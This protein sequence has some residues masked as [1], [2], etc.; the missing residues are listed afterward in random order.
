MQSTGKIEADEQRVQQAK[1][2]AL[3]KEWLADSEDKSTKGIQT[4][5]WNSAKYKT[6]FSQ[7]PL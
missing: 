4:I 5:I 6:T 3:K 7:E 1:K 2:Q